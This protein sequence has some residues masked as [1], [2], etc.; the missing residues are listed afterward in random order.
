MP[1]RCKTE[2]ERTRKRKG[3]RRRRTSAGVESRVRVS[4]S[5]VIYSNVALFILRSQPDFWKESSVLTSPSTQ[6]VA[7]IRLGL[8]L[9]RS[10]ASPSTGRCA[11]PAV[12]AASGPVPARSWG[13]AA[14]CRPFRASFVGGLHF[15]GPELLVFPIPSLKGKEIP[16][17]GIA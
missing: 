17:I 15:A 3:R 12:S 16:N 10:P 14:G 8:C 11:A 13:P 2:A 6:V 1:V 7:T 9:L 4:V 5:Y